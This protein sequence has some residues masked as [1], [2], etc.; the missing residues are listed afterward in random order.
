[1]N[2]IYGPHKIPHLGNNANTIE[3]ADVTMRN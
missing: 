2:Q 1:V 3:K